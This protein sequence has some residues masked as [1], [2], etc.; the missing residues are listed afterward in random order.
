MKPMTLAEW[1]HIKD[2]VEKFSHEFGRFPDLKQL[3][4]FVCLIDW[5][6]P[7]VSDDDDE[8]DED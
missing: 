4:G 6:Q 7:S 3:E 8:P 5:P 1:I 2:W